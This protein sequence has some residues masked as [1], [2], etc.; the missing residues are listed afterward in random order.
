MCDIIWCKKK[1]ADGTICDTVN[2]LD[3]YTF[4]NWEGTINCAE[5]GTVYY[6][7]IIQGWMFRGPDEQPAGTK[8][9]TSPVYADHPYDGYTKYLPG[10][11]GRTRP[12]ECLMRD[13]YLGH[14]DPRRFSIRG[15]P[16]RGW[17]NQ[18]PSTGLVGGQAGFK[19]RIEEL[20]PEVWKEFQEMK[21]R[22]EVHDW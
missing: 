10:V 20:S 7:H 17:P 18:P 12:Y 13:V 4:W 3:P 1:K 11:E 9:D 22:G 21:K 6:I 19:W 15:Y 16:V 8:P 2:Y 5:C 14:A